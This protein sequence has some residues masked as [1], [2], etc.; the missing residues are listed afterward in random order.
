VSNGAEVRPVKPRDV[1]RGTRGIGDFRGPRH[2]IFSK[3]RKTRKESGPVQGAGPGREG[4]R[5]RAT[6]GRGSRKIAVWT[7]GPR[8]RRLCNRWENQ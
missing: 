4:R 6:R 7:S 2:R 8:E 3:T 1:A 5:A